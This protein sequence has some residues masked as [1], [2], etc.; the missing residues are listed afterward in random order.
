MYS[1]EQKEMF[2]CIT[3]GSKIFR[4]QKPGF[5][6][7]II[8]LADVAVFVFFRQRG[9]VY[10]LDFSSMVEFPV[11]NTNDTVAVIRKDLVTSECFYNG[12]NIKIIFVCIS[13]SVLARSLSRISFAGRS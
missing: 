5:I 2:T 12:H 3:C 13:V 7:F 11:N 1:A 10:K 6:L 4:N 9:E 8:F